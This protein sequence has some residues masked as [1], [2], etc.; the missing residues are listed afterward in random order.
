MFCWTKF[1]C[2]DRSYHDEWFKHHICIFDKHLTSF[3]SIF[4]NTGFQ[5]LMDSSA[6]EDS[7]ETNNDAHT[8][9]EYMQKK[10]RTDA[11]EVTNP[12]L[13]RIFC[14][15]NMFDRVWGLHSFLHTLTKLSV[16]WIECN[17]NTLRQ[18]AGQLLQ[19]FGTLHTLWK[20][21]HSFISLFKNVHV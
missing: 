14:S 12:W 5:R 9:N 20:V 2:S 15:E 16:W 4:W 1:T 17:M 8:G 18:F 6:L 11:S 13:M 19:N 10:Q 3:H 21:T 7:G